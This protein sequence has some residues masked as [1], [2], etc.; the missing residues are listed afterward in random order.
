MRNVPAP[1]V[2]IFKTVIAVGAA[3]LRMDTIEFQG[4]FW[5][6]PEWLEELNEGSI[7]PTR[8]ICLAGLRYQDLRSDTESSDDFALNVPIPKSV[9][10]GRVQGPD[11]A[12]YWVI[13]SPPLIFRKPAIH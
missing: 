4:L 1:E 6:V 2:R 13:E 3:L 10:E 5:L 9:L 12:I 7:K 8:I 11:S